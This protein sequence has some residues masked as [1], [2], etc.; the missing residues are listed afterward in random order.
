MRGEGLGVYKEL[1]MGG[2]VEE[3]QGRVMPN[4]QGNIL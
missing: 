2:K 4:G 3:D 1:G